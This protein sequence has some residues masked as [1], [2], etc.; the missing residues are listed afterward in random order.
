MKKLATWLAI[1][2]LALQSLLPLVASAK[3]SAALVPV[4]TVDGVTH[5]IEIPAGN[6][7]PEH[8]AHG[9]HCALCMLGADRLA[10]VAGSPAPLAAGAAAGSQLPSVVSPAFAGGAFLLRPH[11]RAPPAA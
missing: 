8:A 5:Y 1:L 4:C 10:A 2:A 9:Q 7:A 11:P 6:T 3:A